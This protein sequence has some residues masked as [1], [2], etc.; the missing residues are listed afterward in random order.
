MV[1]FDGI[2]WGVLL[3]II[4]TKIESFM[5]IGELSKDSLKYRIYCLLEDGPL[6]RQEIADI[7]GIRRS[8]VCSSIGAL[9]KDRRVYMAG[10]KV[11]P[12]TLKRVGLMG[13][14]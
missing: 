2:L 3:D 6:T 12:I 9:L 7:L 8:S 5:S 14:R 1:G 11:D 10:D 4:G 13:V